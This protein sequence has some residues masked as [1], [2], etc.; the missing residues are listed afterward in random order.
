MK[1][2]MNVAFLSLG[3][4]MGDRA[5]VLQKARQ[6]LEL[7]CGKLIKQS[8]LYETDAWGYT[9]SKNYLNQVVMITTRLSP[10]KLLLKLL[11]IE[12]KAGRKRGKARYSD[13]TLDID[14]LFYNQLI[15]ASKKLEV[16]HPRLH[17]RNFVLQPLAQIAPGFVHPILKQKIST[18]FKKCPDKL[19]VRPY[20]F[21][22]NNL[23]VC[24]EGNIGAGKTTLAKA[25]AER[26][27]MLFVPEKFEHNAI[28]P[29]F[30]KEPEKYAEQLEYS[31]LR[32]RFEQLN[33]NPQLKKQAVVS[34]FSFYKCL[35]FAG[36]NL[37]KQKFT[38]FKQTFNAYHK[39][40]K[41][42]DLLIHLH[43]SKTNLAKN[44]QKRGRLYEKQITG[45]Y[46][47][48]LEQEYYNGIQRLKGVKIVS[49]YLPKYNLNEQKKTLILIE[50]YLKETFG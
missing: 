26:L 45:N 16:P 7:A 27:N 12:Q 21:K 32:E 19:N 36:I 46:L 2:V 28:L 13:R 18:L 38:A 47:S 5:A 17:L 23:Y 35:W 1:D 49:I 11:E 22:N 30:Y 39:Q 4:N 33:K 24:V 50:N 44:I 41:K 15:I 43:T 6:E 3:G 37:K 25:L 9:S 14:L 20:P 34:D 48:A 29:L 10:Q 40:L 8:L 42:P 31:F